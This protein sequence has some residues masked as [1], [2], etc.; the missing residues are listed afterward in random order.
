M[1]G[2]RGRA[3]VKP[4]IKLAEKKKQGWGCSSMVAL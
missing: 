3:E 4:E 2:E 1:D